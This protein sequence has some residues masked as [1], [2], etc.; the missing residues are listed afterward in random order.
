MAASTVL[1]VNTSKCGSSSAARVERML[2][3]SSTTNNEHL[4]FAT[5]IPRAC[6]FPSAETRWRRNAAHSC[7]TTYSLLSDCCQIRK[8]GG[9]EA[10][11]LSLVEEMV[12][13]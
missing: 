2:S 13:L 8:Q 12:W 7:H 5:T 4:Y 1:A 6:V 11:G 9:R 10:V 3:S